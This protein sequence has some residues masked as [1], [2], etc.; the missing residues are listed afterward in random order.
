LL[1]LGL[2]F[3]L[4]A[5]AGGPAEVRMIFPLPEGVQGPVQATLRATAQKGWTS[6]IHDETPLTLPTEFTLHTAEGRVAEYQLVVPG[7]YSPPQVVVGRS[8][9]AP[10]T[11]HLYPTGTL[12]GR[13]AA[14]RGEPVPEELSLRFQQPQ[15]SGIPVGLAGTVPCPVRDGAFRCEV[16][17]GVFDLRLRA[18]GYVSKY[19]WSLGVPRQGEL[20]LGTWSLRRGGSLAGWVESMD[21]TLDLEKARVRLEPATLALP[22]D[23]RQEE[24]LARAAVSEGVTR[25]GFFHFGGLAPGL[26]RVVAEAGGYGRSAPMLLEVRENVETTPPVPLTIAPPSTLRVQIEPAV[27]PFHRPWKIQLAETSGGGLNARTLDI[28]EVADDGTYSRGEL[29]PGRYQLLIQDQLGARWHYE[30]VTV[31]EP[32][33]VVTVVLRPLLVEGDLR[34]GGEPLSASLWFGGRN[35]AESLRLE[36]DAQ[37]KFSGALPRPGRWRVQISAEEPRVDRSLPVE[38]DP[39]PGSGVAQVEIL[40]PDRNL[41]GKVVDGSGKPVQATVLLTPHEPDALPDQQVTDGDGRFAF[42]G[43]AEGTVTAQALDGRSGRSSRAA[44]VELAGGRD[45]QPLELVMSGERE[46]PGR[47]VSTAQG[48]VG[49]RI[50]AKPLAGTELVAAI[51]PEARTEVDGSFTLRVSDQADRIELVVMAP[52]F[53]LTTAVIPLTPPPPSPLVI[54]VHP[55]GGTVLL[56]APD[57]LDFRTAWS[58]VVLRH[59]GVEIVYPSVLQ[60]AASFG[61][62]AGPGELRLPMIEFGTIHA[63]RRTPTGERCTEGYLPP[64]GELQ[65]ELAFKR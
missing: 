41:E 42:H 26:Y 33:E 8:G 1:L 54:L 31:D 58:E 48:V 39:G 50:L 12:T 7:Y 14:P 44:T 17:S 25:R 6:P 43:L 2:A 20:R 49:A 34:L 52:G 15:T 18:R 59:D 45:P 16:P 30:Q 27:D 23:P 62:A 13:V 57:A 53:A 56:D 55:A 9:A 40:L 22:T 5:G 4:A 60:W 46:I 63:C 51:Q 37:G 38:V 10:V 21:R 19:L 29:I 11:F 32:A 3:P 36:A 65:L 35:G 61:G 47:I 64:A 28:A 24:Q